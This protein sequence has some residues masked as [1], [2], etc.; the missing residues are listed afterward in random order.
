MKKAI[1]AAALLFLVSAS[2]GAD[3][4]VP[5]QFPTIQAAVDTAVTGDTVIIAPGTYTGFGNCVISI[6]GKIITIRST[7]PND[8]AIISSTIID[9]NALFAGG[10]NISSNSIIEGLTIINGIA[11]Y[12]S[13]AGIYV[14]SSYSPVI[15][16]CI[17]NNNTSLY[18]GGGIYSEGNPTISGCIITGNQASHGGGIYINKGSAIINK[19]VITENLSSYYGGGIYVY[20]QGSL[21]ISDCTITGNQAYNGPGGGIHINTNKGPVT[22]NKCVITKNSSSSYGGG[23]DTYTEG[24]L[25]ISGCTIGENQASNGAGGGIYINKGAAT[26][27]NCVITKNSSSSYG[28]GI[29]SS[30]VGSL[31]ISDCTITGNQ[32]SN[33]G[34][35]YAYYEYPAGSMTIS[36]CT[37]A[38][39]LAS[40]GGGI[41]LNNGLVNI[42]NSFIAAN[43]SQ[44]NGAGVYISSA[45]ALA[46]YCTFAGNEAAGTGG[47]VY[48][49][50]YS[51]SFSGFCDIFW[52]NTDSGGPGSTTAQIK[53]YYSNWADLLY[54]CIQDD[55][56]NDVNIPFGGAANGNIDDD[57]LFV[58][59]PNDGG[60]GWGVGNNDDYGDLHLTKNSPCIDAGGPIYK[61]ANLTDIDGQPR[62]MGRA[63]DIG[64]D[65]YDKIIIVT[66]PKAGDVWAAGS[67]RLIKWSAWGANTVDIL[68]SAN[69]G[70]NWKTI[71]ESVAEANNT[72]LWQIPNYI[73][74]NRCI[75]SVLPAD[76][77]PNVCCRQSELFTI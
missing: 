10:F 48:M 68:F 18:L 64:A 63:T 40:N 76:G 70:D 65:E 24:S 61:S 15:C 51:S 34:G 72:Y 50:S 67:K 12:H 11:R 58:R 74:S 3:L 30:L 28:G 37:I 25:T 73:N 66:K 13:G 71:T 55:N 47:G 17:I 5:G 36:R 39:N 31:A 19:C 21:T 62:V 2:F 33:G 52:G 8:P 20:S 44:I 1:L 38:G 45:S 43:A 6:S 59:E 42:D 75:I 9:C 53:P 69:G 32:A 41:Y 16:N 77:D 22:I 26:F 54:S 57:P 60:D 49:D 35:I 7:D 14:S 27:N 56:A 29:Y 4:L 46:E 23:I